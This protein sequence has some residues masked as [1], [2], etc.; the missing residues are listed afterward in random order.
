MLIA[1]RITLDPNN[2][3]AAYFARAASCTRFAYHWALAE[4]RSSTRRTTLT[5]ASHHR[6]RRHYALT[7]RIWR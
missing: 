3:Q 5:Q 2:V 7:S 4:G 6:P 1:H